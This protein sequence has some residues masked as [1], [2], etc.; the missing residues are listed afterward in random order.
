MFAKLAEHA[1]YN[2]PQSPPFRLSPLSLPPTTKT[3]KLLNHHHHYHNHNH[4]SVVVPQKNF[5]SECH[6]QLPPKKRNLEGEIK[7]RK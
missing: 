6:P 2:I 1:V 7:S 5:F 4:S 3:T